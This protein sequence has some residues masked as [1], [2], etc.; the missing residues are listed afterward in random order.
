MNVFLTESMCFS[1]HFIILY[2]VY[3]IARNK[4]VSKLCL[5]K[6]LNYDEIELTVLNKI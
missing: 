2:I 3:L 1:S 4:T 5:L 6:I